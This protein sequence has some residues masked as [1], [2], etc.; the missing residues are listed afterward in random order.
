MIAWVIRAVTTLAG[1]DAPFWVRLA[2]PL[3]HGVT[4]LIL[5]GLAGRLWGR[6]A[7]LATGL[8][9]ATL[10]M[11]ALGSAIIS[12]DTIMFVF[13]AGAMAAWVGTLSRPGVTRAVLAGGLLGLAF[14]S[15]YAALYYLFGA[16]LAAIWPVA[17]PGWRAAMTALAAFLLVIAPNV[18]WNLANGLT[19]V[20]H[21]L[22]NADW[23]R[24]PG[25]RAAL[26]PASLLSFFGAQF[27]VFGPVSMAAL[28][29]C[30]LGVAGRRVALRPLWLSLAL[31]PI[32]VVC[33]QA[34]LSRAYAN[35]AAS[36]YLAG[37][38]LVFP[39]LLRHPRWLAL[40]FALNGAVSL[41]L[42]LAA[43]FADRLEWRGRLAL[44]RYVGQAE[45]SRALI[46]ATREEGL[47][48]LVAS[49][50][51]ILADLFYTGRDA[52]LALY[53]LPV[54]G[55][56]PHHYALRYALPAGEAPVALVT[57]DEP[58]PFC[59]TAPARLKA[60]TPAIGA[61]RGHQITLWRVPAGC[62][63]GGGS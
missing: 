8:G 3:F 21:T 12:T 61:Y 54:S 1:S 60:W 48:T 36:A 29:A 23:V 47:D 58:P 55:R 43:V 15:K 26:N 56:A 53:A 4:A 40:S 22:D 41:A 13:L 33:A 45:M 32:L 20:E 49:H 35:W 31:P 25:T 18:L 63:N 9:Y 2:A 37:A 10:P 39:L 28:L 38:M 51:D 16:A 62:L 6:A 57:V 34:L 50:R 42:P 44:E 17:R 24:D 5:G 11:V 14:L 59:L 7:A 52:G 30:I 19:T 27:A 46:A